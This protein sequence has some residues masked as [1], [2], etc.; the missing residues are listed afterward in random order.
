FMLRAGLSPSEIFLVIAAILVLR[1]FV[2]TAVPGFVQRIGLRNALILGSLLSGVEFLILASFDGSSVRL[3]AFVVA[4]ALCSALYWT[5]YHALY[6]A[7]GDPEARGAQVGARGLLSTIATVAAPAVGGVLLVA[8]GPWA[9]FGAAAVTSVAAVVPLLSIREP[10]VLSAPPIG[11]FRA[12]REGI[13]LFATDGFVT[14]ISAFAWE[15]IS[16]VS[17]GER[18]DVFGGVLAVASLAGA[19]AGMAFGRFI[20]T[21]HGARAV[22]IN[23]AAITILLLLKAACVGSAPAIAV[24]SIIANLLGGLYLPVLMTAVYNDGKRAACT[25]RFHVMAE[26]GWDVGGTIAC[27]CAAIAWA[28]GVRPAAILLF[29]VVG[30]LPQTW[31]ALRRYR[32]HAI[33]QAALTS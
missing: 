5:C 15:I 22:W 28:G 14:S 24:A 12:V 2:R 23:A 26:A 10:I 32:E 29:A 1:F 8:F 3:F 4:D 7:L 17:F 11:A 25:L 33:A 6:A 27:V 19:L 9:S 31:L 20:D 18:Y 21:G 13:L 16:F 30:V